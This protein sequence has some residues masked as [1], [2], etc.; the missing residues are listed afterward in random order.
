MSG[1]SR[2]DTVCNFKSCLDNKSPSDDVCIYNRKE[3]NVEMVETKTIWTKY[4]C[5]C[6][7]EE[8]TPQE[9]VCLLLTSGAGHR[10]RDREGKNPLLGWIKNITPSQSNTQTGEKCLEAGKKAA[11]EGS[12]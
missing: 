10:G 2:R 9:R 3:R 12:L 11:R 7:G 4:F 5:I 6:C 8:D 1:M